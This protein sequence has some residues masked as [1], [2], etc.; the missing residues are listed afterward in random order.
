MP[1]PD[2][3]RCLSGAP[4]HGFYSNSFTPEEIAKLDTISTDQFLADT[5]R[6]MLTMAADLLRHPD[7]STRDRLSLLKIIKTITRKVNP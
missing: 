4:K 3:S 5:K 1:K 6:W 7:L 2:Q